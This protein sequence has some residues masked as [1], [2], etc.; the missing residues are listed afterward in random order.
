[1]SRPHPTPNKDTTMTSTSQDHASTV[2]QTILDQ[3]GGYRRVGMMVGGKNF[4][5]HSS[6]D[7]NPALSFKLGRGAKKKINA[8]QI[9]L[10]PDDLYT[11][12]F[13]RIWGSK[14]TVIETFPACFA[15]S[16]VDLFESRTG[17]YL[18]F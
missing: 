10:T 5:A 18:S 9:E 4:T 11:V 8:V 1:M 12:T 15:D 17:F 16:L 6:L 14:V 2:A 3:L 7:G 13:Q